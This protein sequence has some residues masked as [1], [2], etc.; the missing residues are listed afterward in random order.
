[1]INNLFCN[2]MKN[3]CVLMAAMVALALSGC[4][5]EEENDEP[6]GEKIASGLTGA[7]TWTLSR[8]SDSD[9][10][11]ISGN[12]PMGS[13]NSDVPA[14]WAVYDSSIGTIDIREG[15]TSVGSH[16]FSDCIYLSFVTIGDSV[17]SIGSY[18]FRNCVGLLSITLGHSVTTIGDFAFTDCSGLI[19]VISLNPVPPSATNTYYVYAFYRPFISATTLKVPAGSVVAYKATE[20]WSYFGKIVAIP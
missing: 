15:V 11:T 10:L 20:P 5:K 3:L 19:E 13:Y 1:M 12:G 17:T 9:I 7:C 4:E 6:A 2:S 18:A 14:P 16:A 8:V